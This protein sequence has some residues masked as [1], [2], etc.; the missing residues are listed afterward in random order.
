MANGPLGGNMGT[1]PVPPQP[2]QVSFE[3]T[4]QSRGNFNNFLKSIPPTTAMTPLPP[5]GSAPMPPMGGNPMANID[6]FNQPM[7]MMGMNQPP[8]N[9]MMQPP[10]QTPMMMAEVVM[11]LLAVQTSWVKIIC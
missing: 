4:A 2:P 10:M 1:P 7:G 5:M 3:T 11:F 8:M 9:P 6:I